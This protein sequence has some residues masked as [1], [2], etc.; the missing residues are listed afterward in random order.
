M[1]NI[2]SKILREDDY[3]DANEYFKNY[4]NNLRNSAV[5]LT[6]LEKKLIA[7]K[8]NEL[9]V[10]NSKYQKYID[11]AKQIGKPD[12]AKKYYELRDEARIAIFNKYEKEFDKIRKIRLEKAK[13]VSGK[14]DT[15]GINPIKARIALVIILYICFV[16]LLYKWEQSSRKKE[17][18]KE[19]LR[20][21]ISFLERGKNILRKIDKD[22]KYI[23]K[24]DNVQKKQRAK[25]I[26]IQGM[27][28]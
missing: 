10:L 12:T 11:N 13:S 27:K 7:Q 16:I 23:K 14:L 18:R 5:E 8:E 9:A 19:M 20:D 2:K 3:T 26:K 25:L 1:D 21:R 15:A 24:V 4:M 28:N 17:K 22:G 6:K